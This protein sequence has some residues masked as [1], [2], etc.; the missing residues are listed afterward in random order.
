MELQGIEIKILLFWQIYR[1]LKPLR[2]CTFLLLES[3]ETFKICPPY[4]EA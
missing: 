3:I 4:F 1:I 2:T